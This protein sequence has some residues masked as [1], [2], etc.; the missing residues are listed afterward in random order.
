MKGDILYNMIMSIIEIILG[1]LLIIFCKDII[2]N[3][4]NF[5][6][7]IAF[8][9]ICN[10]VSVGLYTIIVNIKYIIFRRRNNYDN[11]KNN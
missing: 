11:N 5:K 9:I 2:V 7:L 10:S 1:A 6:G 3:F 8:I 4:L